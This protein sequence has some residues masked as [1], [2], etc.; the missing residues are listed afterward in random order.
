MI[1]TLWAG[2]GGDAI[3]DWL[4]TSEIA[5][6]WDELGVLSGKSRDLLTDLLNSKKPD[7]DS[8]QTNN[9]LCLYEFAN[10]M[11]KGD[12]VVVMTGLTTVGGV[13]Q[14]EGDYFHNDSLKS[15]KNR[16][17]VKWLSKDTRDLTGEEFFERFGVNH[18]AKKTLTHV[19]WPELLEWALYGGSM[20][21]L[22]TGI[23]AKLKLDNFNRILL[24]VNQEEREEFIN[25]LLNLSLVTS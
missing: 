17:K 7:T 2:A 14:I 4:R 1:W 9:S 6:G 20:R 5:I 15:M 19:E 13:A 10:V 16:R 3:D 18:V 24:T 22:S 11:K 21:I 12:K 25:T 8:K 23:L